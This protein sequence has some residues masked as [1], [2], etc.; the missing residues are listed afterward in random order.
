MVRSTTT[1]ELRG[2]EELTEVMHELR[3]VEE[4]R[5]KRQFR[6]LTA[7]TSSGV[8]S[9]P[10][11]SVA[12]TRRPSEASTGL[13]AL[14]E[15]RSMRQQGQLNCQLPPLW[16]RPQPLCLR[17]RLIPHRP[18][19]IGVRTCRLKSSILRRLLRGSDQEHQ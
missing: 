13:P 10:S 6:D 1:Q 5:G 8:I 19:R 14:R 11:S 7:E 9:Q 2:I 16:P 18:T 3:D 17:Q 4:R 12:E 15:W